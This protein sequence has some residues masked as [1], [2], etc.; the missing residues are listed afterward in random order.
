VRPNEL[1]SASESII[2]VAVQPLTSADEPIRQVN[3]RLK[4][5]GQVRTALE[6]REAAYPVDYAT[7]KFAVADARAAEIVVE[8]AWVSRVHAWDATAFC[9]RPLYFE[10]ENLERH[11]RSFGLLQPAVSAGHFAGRFLAWPYL[12]GATSPQRCVYN[13]GRTPPGTYAP[14]TVVRPPLSLRG[15]VLEAGAVVA[16]PLI[17]P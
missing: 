8:R 6:P 7:T 5:I 10:D 14:Y 1:R 4:P 16:L 9:H 3:D 17:V 2:T 13:L 11:G 15:A 12:A